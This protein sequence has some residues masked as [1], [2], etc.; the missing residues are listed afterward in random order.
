MVFWGYGPI[1]QCFGFNVPRAGR[2]LRRVDSLLGRGA[3]RQAVL[4][5]ALEDW[6][7]RIP[8]W[9]WSRDRVR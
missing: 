8:C 3:N 9:W 2:Q 1:F 4:G 5:L 7:H 6:E